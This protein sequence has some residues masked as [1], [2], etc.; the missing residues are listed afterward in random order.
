M[1]NLVVVEMLEPIDDLTQNFYRL[2]FS[3]EPAFLDIAIEIPLIAVLQNQI[4]IVG[5]FL[6]IVQL[7]DVVAFA[8]L[9]HF[10][11]TL[12]QLLELPFIDAQVPL[13]LSRRIDFTAMSL[14]V[15]RS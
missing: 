5:S 4:V 11:L 13:T 15:A 6:H 10:D 12:Q 8:A 14:L 2:F 7:D 3:E 9:E 1:Q